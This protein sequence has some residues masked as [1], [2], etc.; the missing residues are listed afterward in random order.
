M[1]NNAN[2]Q[3][4]DKLTKVCICKS[5]SRLKIKEAIKNGARTVEEVKAA[6]GAT[7][8]GCNGRRC[9]HKIE[10]LIEREK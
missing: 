7:T 4:M 1:E 8:G 10:E 3:I 9:I 2:E 6:T 5:I